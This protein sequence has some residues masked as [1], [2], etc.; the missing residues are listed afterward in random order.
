MLPSKESRK[1]ISRGNKGGSTPYTGVTAR[2]IVL[3]LCDTL[4]LMCHRARFTI[5]VLLKISYLGPFLG[6]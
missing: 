3:A 4:V 1:R 2:A 6:S 5:E